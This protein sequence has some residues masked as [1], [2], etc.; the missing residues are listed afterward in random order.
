MTNSLTTTV[1]QLN[2]TVK[3]NSPGILTAFGVAG[4]LGSV[5]MAADARHK[6]DQ[7]LEQE[8]LFRH[9]EY[10]DDQPLTLEDKVLLTWK[11]YAPTAIMVLTTAGCILG[12]NH[13]QRKRQAVLASLLA[14]AERGLSEY[15]AKVVETIGE[16][17]EE[18]IRGEIAGDHIQQNPPQT[19]TIVLTGRGTYLCHDPFSGQ[20]F[21]S[22]KEAIEKAEIKFNQQLLREGWLGINEFY[23]ELGISSMEMGDEMGWIAER[24]MMEISFVSQMV[25]YDGITEPCCV[26]TYRVTPHH[27]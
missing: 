17:K 13:I 16:K 12:A 2:N 15:Q 11:V 3:K 5:V 24:N 27:I 22:N 23:Y 8:V 9:E 25:T 1:H 4:L 14:V 10:G 6:A 19:N 20:Y 26:I 7:L 21:R 18:L